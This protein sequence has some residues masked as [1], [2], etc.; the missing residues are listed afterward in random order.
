[1]NIE[2]QKEGKETV[3]NIGIYFDDE[4]ASDTKTKKM[5]INGKVKINQTS[6]EKF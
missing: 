1:M 4:T 6:N 3:I 5:R 2:L